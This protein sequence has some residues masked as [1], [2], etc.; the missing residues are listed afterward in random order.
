MIIPLGGIGSRFQKEGYERPKPFIRVLGKEMILWVVDSLKLAPEDRLVIVY[1]PGFMSLN[2]YMEIVRER[3]PDVIFVQ[4]AGP[5]RGAAETVLFG[6]QLLIG[7]QLLES[8]VF[9][10]LD[11]GTADGLSLSR[12][13]KRSDKLVGRLGSVAGVVDSTREEL[14]ESKT[15]LN[16][17]RVEYES[18]DALANVSHGALS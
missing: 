18:T 6:L 11:V 2:D 17:G 14:A 1:N 16:C 5:T 7:G 8:G 9:G 13:K 3:V 4:L 15:S 12:M 10:D